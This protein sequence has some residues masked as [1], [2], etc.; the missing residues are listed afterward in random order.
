VTPDGGNRTSYYFDN[1]LV[2]TS[3]FEHQRVAN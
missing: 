2:K 1:P 3:Q